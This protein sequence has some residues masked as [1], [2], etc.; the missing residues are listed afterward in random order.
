MSQ[1]QFHIPVMGIGFTIDTPLR[2]S[3]LGISSVISMVDDELMEKLRAFYC[4]K[5]ALP[6]QAIT[7]RDKDF[8]AGRVT[9]WLNLVKDLADKRFKEIRSSQF[10]PGS[11]I[12]RYFEMLP[13]NNPLLIKYQRLKTT[14]DRSEKK[15]LEQELRDNMVPGVID[16]N[17][18]TKIDKTNYRKGEKLPSEHNDAHAALRGFAQSRLNSSLV[19]SAGINRSLYSYIPEFED[20]FPDHTGRLKKRIV[21]KVSDYK[22]AFIQGKFLAKKG[23]WISEYR[24]ES[25]LNCGGHAFASDGFLMGP[26]LETFKN[27]RAELHSATHTILVRTLKAMG[28]P[29][30]KNRLPIKITVQGGIGTHQEHNMLMR[31]YEVERTGWGTPFLL[32]PEVTNVDDTTLELL[33]KAKE[34][35]LYLSNIS[36]IGVLFNSLVGNT[37]D[38]EKQKWIEAG[39]P[40]SPCPKH[41]LVSST[42]FTNRPICTASRQYQTKMLE[43]LATKDLTEDAR[44]KET[45]KIHEKSCICVGLG[46]AALLVNKID[47]SKEGNGVTICPGP[48]LAYFSKILSLEDMVDH[49]YGRKQV[50]DNPD[51]RPH[52]FIKELEMYVGYLKERVQDSIQPLVDKQKKYFYAFQENLREGIAYYKKAVDR[53]VDDTQFARARFLQDLSELEIRLSA[54]ISRDCPSK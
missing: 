3:P 21:L 35:D 48:N 44:Q 51:I 50:M 31:H 27:S 24:V 53:L 34:N 16:V 6:Y 54:V 7:P 15:A 22:S 40:G 28:K 47:T 36:P 19:L 49:I 37:K 14:A 13:D 33:L 26:I 4:N 2:V 39:T 46:T 10:K 32:V 9:A 18:M 17:I 20:F 12:A 29:V 25:G 52:M 30:P 8:R 38:I 1:H 23:I 5:H 11:D 45:E 43:E 42:D 41:F